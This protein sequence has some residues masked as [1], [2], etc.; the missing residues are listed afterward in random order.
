LLLAPGSQCATGTQYSGTAINIPVGSE[1]N[2]IAIAGLTGLANSVPTSVTKY[3]AAVATPSFDFLGAAPSGSSY[4]GTQQIQLLDLTSGAV[5]CYSTTGTASISAGVCGTG[6]TQYTGPISVSTTETISAIAGVASGLA[7]SST[8]SATFSINTVTA[9]PT[10]SIA[11]GTYGGPQVL[12]LSDSIVGAAICYTTDGST[13]SLTGAGCGGTSTQY[14]TG[15]TIPVSATTV[16]KALAGGVA[17]MTNSTVAGPWIYNPPVTPTITPVAQIY[18]APQ[19]VTIS[20]LTTNASIFYTTTGVAPTCSSTAYNSVT[21]ITVAATETIQA[22]ACVGTVASP[23]TSPKTF[24]IDVVPPVFTAPAG[25]TYYSLALQ[26]LDPTAGAV[27]SSGTYVATFS[28]PLK[29]ALSDAAAGTIICYT[30]NATTPTVG[31][32]PACGIGSTLYTTALNITSQAEIRAVAGT[33]TV[34]SPISLLT[35]SITPVEQ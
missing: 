32:G 18:Y 3:N 25:A 23:V 24:T 13:P 19:T 21:G 28:K 7:N 10:A 2:V 1:T 33:G 9:P 20:D 16:V 17:G 5:I 30:T 34:S 35:L 8:A 31:A 26:S 15:I 22:I 4:N 11:S 14:T 12:Q 27:I 6:S 29:V